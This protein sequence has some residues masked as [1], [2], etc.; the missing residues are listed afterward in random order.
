MRFGVCVILLVSTLLRYSGTSNA[1]EW[2]GESIIRDLSALISG[3]EPWKGSDGLLRLS[4]RLFSVSVWYLASLPYFLL[5]DRYECSLVPSPSLSVYCVGLCAFSDH[6]VGLRTGLERE[7]SPAA[8]PRPNSVIAKCFRARAAH[9]QLPLLPTGVRFS[10][11][12]AHHR[13]YAPLEHNL[14][15]MNQWWYYSFAS[16]ALHTACTIHEL[17]RFCA[18]ICAQTPLAPTN[19]DSQ[20]L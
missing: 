13:T 15:P 5:E 7:S 19:I 10:G 4:S 11:R 18:L 20:G 9:K 16:Y 3:V 14:Q 8:V 6:R 17:Y 1:L 12:A 2:P